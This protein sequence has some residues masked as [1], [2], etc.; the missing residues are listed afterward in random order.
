MMMAEIMVR[1][2]GLTKEPE[3]REFEAEA[4]IPVVI[5]Q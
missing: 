5:L 3:G 4:T 1:M 2:I